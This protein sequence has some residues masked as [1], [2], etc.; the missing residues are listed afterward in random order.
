MEN[1]AIYKGKGKSKGGKGDKSKGKGV[2]GKDKGREN[3]VPHDPNVVCYYCSGEGHRKIDCRKRLA[4]LEKAKREGR[5]VHALEDAEPAAVVNVNELTFVAPQHRPEM[6]FLYGLDQVT[7]NLQ[8]NKTIGALRLYDGLVMLDSGAAMNACPYDFVGQNG[9]EASAEVVLQTAGG[10][11]I[12]HYGQRTVTFKVT[13]RFGKDALLAVVFEVVDVTKPIIA[14]STMED[15]GWE[16]HVESNLR[17]LQ[18]GERTVALLRKDRVYWMEADVATNEELHGLP[19]C[20][21]PDVSFDEAET[22]AEDGALPQQVE[23]KAKA[24]TWG[25]HFVITWLLR[26]VLNR[27]GTGHDDETP[28]E[29]AK[30]SP[31][32]ARSSSS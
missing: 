31:T 25:K 8:E 29:K 20:P 27:F 19:M 15:H 26:L 7:V 2:K 1:D 9:I 13:D 21:L 17:W 18:K 22:K 16:M 30:A 12:K 5:P 24:K 23:R 14:L 4:D 10:Q 3:T 11:R 32:M 6:L 28:Y